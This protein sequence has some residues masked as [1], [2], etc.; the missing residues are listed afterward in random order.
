MSKKYQ[1]QVLDG[2]KKIDISKMTPA[3]FLIGA[4]LLEMKKK[5]IKYEP[6]E[7]KEEL[8][9]RMAAAMLL[10]PDLYWRLAGQFTDMTW[11][12][13]SDYGPEIDEAKR[14]GTLPKV[15]I[16]IHKKRA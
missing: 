15:E 3:D 9:A 4:A 5:G 7:P 11:G 14:K 6:D 12:D 16:I 2:G 10:V 1:M 8:I 13:Q